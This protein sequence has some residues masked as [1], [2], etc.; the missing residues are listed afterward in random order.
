[1]VRCPSTWRT[2]TTRPMASNT[3]GP[4]S[5]TLQRGDV[6][7]VAYTT[8]SGYIKCGA[9]AVNGSGAFYTNAFLTSA[10][11]SVHMEGCATDVSTGRTV[12]TAPW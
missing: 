12:C 3:P 9:V 4:M 8:G 2:A 6:A 5:K 1:M 11:S 10:S 7:W